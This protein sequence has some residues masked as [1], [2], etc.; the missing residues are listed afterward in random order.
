[1]EGK[2]LVFCH[3]MGTLASLKARLETA[4]RRRVAIF[5]EELSPDRRDIEVA[6]FRRV[7]GPVFLV[8]TECGG[9]G[10]NFEFCRRLVLF[11]LPTDPAQVEQRIGRLDRI[12]R[13]MPVEIVYFRPPAPF[14]RDL[15]TLYEKIGLFTEPLGGL[16]RSLSHVAAAIER[17]ARLS[18]K[19]VKLPIDKLVAEVREAAEARQ[20]AVYHHL[21]SGG[22]GK[23]LADG[24]LSRVP[25]GLDEAMKRFVLDACAIHGLTFAE[26]K[27]AKTFYVEFGGD[28]LVEHLPGVA[29]GTRFLGTF[30]REE[31]VEKEELEF[32]ASGHP[33]VEGLFGELEDGSRG[34][35]ALVKLE[36]CTSGGDGLFFVHRRPEGYEAVAIDLSG[37]LRPEW[38]ETIVA[39]RMELRGLK[40]DD[41]NA[42]LLERKANPAHWPRL[43]RALA[44]RA[45]LAG[46]VVAA[47]AFRLMR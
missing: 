6:E 9:E 18:G 17:A 31:A 12:S 5:H 7:D 24:I 27:G 33:L 29:G 4:T 46:P 35:V 8:S 19:G 23:E 26:R 3:D 44:R 16:E 25:E 39:R 47:A 38:K 36:G 28:A 11:D 43:C 40:V 21:H 13:T 22:Y 42:R 34:R 2:T 41:W 1:E 30:D 37:R 32:F 20:R 45:E 10:R 15:V 14:E